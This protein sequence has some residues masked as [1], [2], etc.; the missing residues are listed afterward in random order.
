MGLIYV[1]KLKPYNNPYS[2]FGECAELDCCLMLHDNL[3]NTH[4]EQYYDIVA[5]LIYPGTPLGVVH[6]TILSSQ[7]I[8]IRALQ[9][10]MNPNT[11][12]EKKVLPV[13]SLI[14]T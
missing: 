13:R 10:I 1:D 9:L 11:P 2:S 5:K 8:G 14:F 7:I 6:Y 12:I 3:V 4:K